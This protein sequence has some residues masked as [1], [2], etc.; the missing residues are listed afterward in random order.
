MIIIEIFDPAL[1]ATLRWRGQVGSRRT[2]PG[3]MPQQVVQK[4]PSAVAAHAAGRERLEQSKLF[5]KIHSETLTRRRSVSGFPE[6]PVSLLRPP[7]PRDRRRRGIF[8]H[9]GNP[10]SISRCGS[11]ARRAGGKA[12][13]SVP[14]PRSES[15]R[16]DRYWARRKVFRRADAAEDPAREAESSSPFSSE[17]SP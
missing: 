6:P 14:T 15:S 5:F 1:R 16:R 9:R 4:F 12:A 2:Q 11:E 3:R 10:R 17:L 8:P 13:H 7:P